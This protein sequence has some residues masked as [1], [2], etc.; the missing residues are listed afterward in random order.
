VQGR[1][2][3][4]PLIMVTSASPEE[5][6]SQRWRSRILIATVTLAVL[7]TAVAAVAL[8]VPVWADAQVKPTESPAPPTTTV[9][10]QDLTIS[11]DFDGQL[12]Y[13]SATP[14]KGQGAGIVT[15]LPT[16]GTVLE[17]GSV[18]YRVNDRPVPVIQGDTALFRPV[19]G[20]GLH[21]SDVTMIVATLQA[22]GFLYEEEVDDPAEFST[23]PDFTEALCDWQESVGLPLTGTL[24][25]GDVL[26]LPAPR[27]IA[28]V[29]AAVGDSV[30]GELMQLGPVDKSITLQV[31]PSQMGGIVKDAPATLTLP[32]GTTATGTVASI[33]T[34]I[35]PTPADGPTS[36]DPLKLTITVIPADQAV[37]AALDYAPI[38][39]TVVTTTK[40]GV[41]TV[42]IAALLALKEGGYALQLVSGELIPV[43]VGMLTATLAEVSGNGVTNGLT[44]VTA[45]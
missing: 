2:R 21:G 11:T 12:S 37:F 20:S 29:T 32:D 8:L 6:P 15:A 42:P 16:P 26:V 3:D 28:S 19:D 44:V 5:P 43:E 30:T 18:A 45:A 35:P 14:I 7:L 31:P 10:Q 34:V 4:R 25:P 41:L 38:R 17:P 24:S 40:A 27:R 9:T 36:T 13:G 1:R 33:A 39:V 23:G 22:A